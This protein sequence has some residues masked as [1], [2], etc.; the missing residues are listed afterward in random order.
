MQIKTLVNKKQLKS[1]SI[2]R[3]DR[4]L[5]MAGKMD[6][7]QLKKEELEEIQRK[8]RKLRESKK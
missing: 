4:A 7:A 1:S 6:E 5:L 2:F 8:D 3:E